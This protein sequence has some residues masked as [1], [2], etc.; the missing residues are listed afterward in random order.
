M[1]RDRA[2]LVLLL[3]LLLFPAGCAKPTP[4]RFYALT[5]PPAATL[6]GQ[7]A[8]VTV[9]VK[10]LAIVPTYASN[11]L[12]FRQDIHEVQYYRTRRWSERPQQMITRLVRQALDRSGLVG[13]VTSGLEERPPDFVLGGEILALEQLQAGEES[14]AHLAMTLQLTRFRDEAVVWRRGFD[15]RVKVPPDKVR[16]VVRAISSTLEQELQQALTELAPVLRGEA[17]A[18]AA[19]ATPGGTTAAPA[20]ASAVHPG[21]DEGPMGP[22]APARLGPDPASP[23]AYHPQL[24]ADAT[25]L[26]AGRGALFLPA[27]SQPEQEPSLAVYAD[28][29]QVAGGR[30][31]ERVVLRPGDYQVRLGNGAAEQQL[32]LPVRIEEGRDTLVVPTWAALEVRVVNDRFIPFR[33]GYELLDGRTRE[34]YGLGFG[35]DEEQGETLRVW[36]LRPGLYK[37]IRPGGTYRDRTNFATVQLDPGQLT[38]FTLVLD[39]DTGDFRG[40]GVVD[41]REAE[42]DPRRRWRPRGIIGGD[43]TFNRSTAA[44]SQDGWN[45]DVDLFFDGMLTFQQQPHTVVSRL[46]LEEGQT[47]TPEKDRFT[48]RLDRIYLHTIY[49]YELLP[50]FGPYARAGLESALLTRTYDFDQPPD[51]E[52]VDASGEHVAWQRDTDRVELGGFLSPLQLKAGAGGNF[53]LVHT[54]DLDLALRVGPGI[55]PT[56]ARGLLAFQNDRLEPVASSVLYGVEAT[57]VGMVRLTRWVTLTSEVDTLVP[58]DGLG[59]TEINWRS[60]AV[61]RLSSLASLAYRFNL[62]RRPRLELADPPTTEQFVQLRFSYTL[63]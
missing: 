19:T 56:Y 13:Q 48:N 14:F 9:R 40:A 4:R 5:F 20:P 27:L 47:R 62:Y 50:W 61:L 32:A 24:L 21:P 17:A 42:L 1:S 30:M 8:P 26:P 53:Q 6:T 25:P 39:Q 51:V 37:I 57:V 2:L 41:A 22:P 3:G 44:A 63:F 33:G 54:T 7:P 52:E 29:E 43:L 23:L 11:E 34:E 35:A 58:L 28:G 60:Q 38:R 10:E 59:D 49:S 16:A 45:L 31:G 55:W 46:E 36:V 12:V 18:E 15:R